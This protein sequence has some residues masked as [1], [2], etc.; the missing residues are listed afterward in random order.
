MVPWTLSELKAARKILLLIGT[1]A[2]TEEAATLAQVLS[3]FTPA[4]ISVR[5]WNGTGDGV[6]SSS[7]DKALDNLLRRRDQTANT[8]GL[9]GLGLKPWSPS[10]NAYDLAI[11]FRS[12]RAGLPPKMAAKEIAWGVFQRSES[13]R[14][15]AVLPGLTTLEK[16]GT[17]TNCDGITQSF[18]TVIASPGST[19]SVRKVLDGMKIKSMP[20]QALSSSAREHAREPV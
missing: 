18:E 3:S 13:A 10:D 2:S 17:Y 12:G 16:F 5:T 15:T 7:D 14:F 9:E 1:D 20:V 4:D 6:Q 11:F 19:A 8:K